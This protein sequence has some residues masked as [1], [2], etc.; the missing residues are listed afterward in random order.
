MPEVDPRLRIVIA[1]KFLDARGGDTTC[2]H[3]L[4]EWL[5]A[6]G[7]A[8][9]P[10]GTR[11]GLPPAAGNGFPDLDL[12]PDSLPADGGAAR[13]AAALYRPQAAAR[14]GLLLQRRSPDLVHLHNIHYQLTGSV[15]AAARARHL[16]VVWTL[17]DVN[18]FCPNVSGSRAGKPCLE[19]HVGRFHSCVRLNCRG[20]L[21]ASA[22]AA[23]E[24][25]LL[26]GL[27]LWGQVTRFIAPSRF[28]RLLLE[29][30]GVEEERIA[31]LEPGVD[32]QTF[33]HE[34]TGGDGLLYA[35]R[36]A[37]EKGVDVL[38]RALARVP[39]ARLTIAGDGPERA[40]LE[41]LAERLAPGR[42]RFAGF[43]PRRELALALSRADALVLPSVCLEVAPFAL[44]E[45]AAA[46]RP[47]VASRVGGVPEWVEEEATGLLTPAG[48]EEPLASALAEILA[49]R[50]RAG[51]MGA[52]ARERAR[53]RFDPQRHCD[54]L[55]R[56]YRDAVGA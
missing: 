30:S 55:E 35:G 46:G 17:H 38:L 24:A 43:L 6:R 28:T 37:P 1:S 40:A 4:R 34:P 52:E 41:A 32:V 23:A 53:V 18:L 15:I 7:H 9:F 51:R 25:Y 33:A 14:L 26:R 21:A 31:L 11:A 27:G 8:V 47:V 54:S 10:F 50:A 20:S 29:L 56:V 45:A 16:P 48:E 22:A 36:L 49:Q 42:V 44:L 19:C 13:R 3:L 5:D 39:Q 12:F 2:V